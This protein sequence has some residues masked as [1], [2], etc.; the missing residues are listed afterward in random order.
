MLG[1]FYKRPHLIF[2]FQ[3]YIRPMDKHKNSCFSNLDSTQPQNSK[4]LIQLVFNIFLA[5]SHG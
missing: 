4:L 3:C 2:H 1:N 5:L